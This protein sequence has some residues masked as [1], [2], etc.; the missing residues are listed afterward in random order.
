MKIDAQMNAYM[1]KMFK[2]D[3]D[4]SHVFGQWYMI[5]GCCPEFTCKICHE[6]DKT[7]SDRCKDSSFVNEIEEDEDVKKWI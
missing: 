5:T 6:N 3:L 4:T 7:A 1:N 2:E